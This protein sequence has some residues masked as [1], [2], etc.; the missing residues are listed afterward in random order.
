MN[1]IPILTADDAERA[2]RASLAAARAAG[3]AVTIAIVDAAGVLLALS[4]MDGA[5]AYTV[6][7]A[8]RKARTA[9]AVGVGTAVLAALY[10][11]KPPPAEMMTMPGGIPV[12]SDKLTA[13]AIGVSG[14]T[15]EMDESI[16]AAGLAALAA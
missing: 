1:L 11:D 2:L 5:R 7:L 8:S 14:A 13:G 16:A 9:A 3:V 4:R 15:T 6:D 12:L 10:K